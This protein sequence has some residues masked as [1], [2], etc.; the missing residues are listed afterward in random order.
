MRYIFYL[1][2]LVLILTFS[3]GLLAPWGL[4]WAVPSILLIFVICL[5]L[6]QGSLH[7]IFFAL[8]GG[9]WLDVFFGLPVG[10]FPGA[11]VFIGWIGYSMYQRLSLQ[12][13]WKYYL[14][15]V[16]IAELFLALW[17]WGYTSILFRLHYSPIAVSGFQLLHHGIALVTAGLI[18]AFPIYSIVNTATRLAKKWLRQPLKL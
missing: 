8:L 14:I 10:S 17:L 5:S 4:G 13:N 7:F 12:S 16:G 3:F 9:L 15:F 6:E 18:S 11:Y 1:L 2:V